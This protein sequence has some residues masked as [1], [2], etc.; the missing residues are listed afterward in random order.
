MKRIEKINYY[1]DIAEIIVERYTRL[2]RNFGTIIFKYIENS[3]PCTLCKKIIINFGIKEIII[4]D[5]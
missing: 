4:I 2:R 1:L 5:I 3:N